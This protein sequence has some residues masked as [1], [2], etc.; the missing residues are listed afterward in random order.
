MNSFMVF[1]LGI[2]ILFGGPTICN[3]YC[4]F[5]CAKPWSVSYCN[6]YPLAWA[7][8]IGNVTLAKQLIEE[9]QDVNKQEQGVN[10][11]P[12]HWAGWMGRSDMAKFLISNGAK[13]TI[14]TTELIT[15]LYFAEGRRCD[16]P[17]WKEQETTCCTAAIE[18]DATIRM[19]QGGCE[20]TG[21]AE[22][23]ECIEKKC[24][25]PEVSGLTLN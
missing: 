7:A 2:F 24:M 4:L 11:T 13:I 3:G 10:E 12:L 8:E 15:P 16:Q 19:L 17:F 1:K 23:L 20:V 25:T 22:N 18:Y 6:K 21:C 5:E 9:G 14:T